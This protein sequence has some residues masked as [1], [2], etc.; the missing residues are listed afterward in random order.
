VLC[1]F[2]IAPNKE[3][4]LNALDELGNEIMKQG[5]NDCIKDRMTRLPASIDAAIKQRKVLKEIT[6]YKYALDQSSIGIGEYNFFA[7]IISFIIKAI[8]SLFSCS[9]YI[10]GQIC[11]Q[12]IS[13][14][15]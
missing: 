3:S 6:D 10:P 1:E 5:A 7:A 2:S 4:F 12:D 9:W 13:L 14:R 15:V 11:A 8:F